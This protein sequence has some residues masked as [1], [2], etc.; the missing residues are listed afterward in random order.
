MSAQSRVMSVQEIDAGFSLL[1]DIMFYA[2]NPELVV[3]A[4]KDM[5]EQAA[6]TEEELEKSKSARELIQKASTIAE[7]HQEHKSCLEQERETHVQT[8]LAFAQHCTSEDLRLNNL[9]TSL[10]SRETE[11][12]TKEAEFIAAQHRLS[13][14]KQRLQDEHQQAMKN[15]N[16]ALE[17]VE[18]VQEQNRKE[19]HRL[20]EFEA[21]L[22]R[23]AQRMVASATQE[24]EEPV[25][26]GA[27][28]ES[29]A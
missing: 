26:N 29:G 22:N 12:A 13:T 24:T 5:R 23:R 17:A 3:Q 14:E 8:V 15:V 28:K 7:Q 10:A 6:L 19:G 27:L 11:L 1:K 2:K 18:Q 16:K 21:R 9:Q 25:K 20:S 4:H